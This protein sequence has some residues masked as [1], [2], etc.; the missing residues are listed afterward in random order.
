MSVKDLIAAAFNKDAV[1]FEETLNSVMQEKMAVAIQSRFSPAVYEEEIDLEESKDED[2]D[3]DEDEEGDEEDMKEEAEELDELS[4]KTLGAY[5]KAANRD[6]YLAGKYSRDDKDARAAGR[7]RK[8]GVAMAVDK[9]TKEE[10][11]LDEISGAKIGTYL[12][13]ARKSEADLDKKIDKEYDKDDFNTPEN[14]A[15]R[16]KLS[17][18]MNKRRW[19]QSKAMDKLTGSSFAKVHAT[20]K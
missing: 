15:V 13:K 19:G 3:E 17:R 8:A 10:V 1:S 5:V 16:K 14:K 11:E 2:E 9:L 4:K 6:T 20:E 18:T 12:I 7:K